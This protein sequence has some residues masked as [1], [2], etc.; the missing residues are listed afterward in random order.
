MPRPLLILIVV[1]VVFVALLVFLAGRN[2]ERAQT[3]V[4]KVVTLENIT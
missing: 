4:E 2:G 1:L 3:H